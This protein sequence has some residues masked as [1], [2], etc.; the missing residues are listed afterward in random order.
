[1]LRLNRVLRYFLTVLLVAVLVAF[2]C[3][4]VIHADGTIGALNG[5]IVCSK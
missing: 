4:K 1:M 3:V 5:V 2:D